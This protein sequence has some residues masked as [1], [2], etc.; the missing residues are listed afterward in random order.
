MGYFRRPRRVCP[1]CIAAAELPLRSG[2][3]RVERYGLAPE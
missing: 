3:C 1:A 2:F